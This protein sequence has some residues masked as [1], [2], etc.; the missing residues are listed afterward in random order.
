MEPPKNG[1]LQ[2]ALKWT[3]AKGPTQVKVAILPD[4]AAWV[5]IQT[6]CRECQCYGVGCDVPRSCCVPPRPTLSD[7]NRC[8][9]VIQGF[10]FPS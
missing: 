6:R 3:I 4:H 8:P 5:C 9:T 10:F 2:K 7:R 1:T